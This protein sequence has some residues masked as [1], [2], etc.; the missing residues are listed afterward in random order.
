MPARPRR[1]CDPDDL[2]RALGLT[3]TADG[4]PAATIIAPARAEQ[5][6]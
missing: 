2:H 6:R 3:A 1:P 5:R 4:P